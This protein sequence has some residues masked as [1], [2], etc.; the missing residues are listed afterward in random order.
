MKKECRKKKKSRTRGIAR[1]KVAKG[2]WPFLNNVKAGC[3][4]ISRDGDWSI[5]L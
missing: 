3:L 4:A 1:A 2:I 5:L